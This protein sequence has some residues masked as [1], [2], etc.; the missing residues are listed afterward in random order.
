MARDPL[1]FTAASANGMGLNVR[2][3]DS[4]TFNCPS[5]MCFHGGVHDPL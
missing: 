3:A 1:F 4:F 5:P 2:G